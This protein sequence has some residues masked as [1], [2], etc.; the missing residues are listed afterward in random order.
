M[1]RNCFQGDQAKFDEAWQMTKTTY[2]IIETNMSTESTSSTSTTGKPASNS[3]ANDD[4]DGDN[5]KSNTS[6]LSAKQ[7]REPL[8]R[9]ETLRTELAR[10]E[11]QLEEEKQQVTCD[12]KIADNTSTNCDDSVAK[13]KPFIINDLDVA[14]AVLDPRQSRSCHIVIPLIVAHHRL[15]HKRR[16]TLL[17][18]HAFGSQSIIQPQ[19]FGAL[20]PLSNNDNSSTDLSSSVRAAIEF[21]APVSPPA[22]LPEI[23][24]I[25][26]SITSTS[27]S[28]THNTLNFVVA[29]VRYWRD[30]EAAFGIAVTPRHI[31]AVLTAVA[32]IDTI[33]VDL[34]TNSE[35]LEV[36]WLIVRNKSN[37][38][39]QNDGNNLHNERRHLR[40]PL[41][42]LASRYVIM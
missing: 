8:E 42:S 21:F 7:E 13:S 35:S 26:R 3:V 22:D 9:W 2:A 28:A 20:Y 36:P 15:T 16:R 41:I 12:D 33:F 23:S 4:D 17:I 11:Q 10:S 39:D 1:L 19:Q 32:L 25:D 29:V 6:N 27:S 31:N 38:D 30:S 34:N 18:A 24:L 5:A 40:G 14:E 37:I